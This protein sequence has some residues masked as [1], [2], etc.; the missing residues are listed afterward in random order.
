MA[1][2]FSGYDSNGFFLW[3]Y[4]KEKIYVTLPRTREELVNRIRQT[5]ATITPVML[6]K[7]RENF[8]RRVAMCLE[9]NDGY[10]EHL[11]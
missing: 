1:S 7:V 5:S 2:T 4:L 10:I 6:S 9:N 3:G 11:L 8:M